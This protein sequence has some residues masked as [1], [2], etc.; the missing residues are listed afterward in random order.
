MIQR[1]S[2][3]RLSLEYW[4]IRALLLRAED[5]SSVALQ[6]KRLTEMD[7]EWLNDL[8]AGKSVKELRGPCENTV[9]NRLRK[10]RQILD[11]ETNTQAI[12]NALKRG[13]IQ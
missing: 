10:V 1:M 9:N 5:E 12:Y 3:E 8:A 7:L 4:E 6:A 11:A 13:I 2:V